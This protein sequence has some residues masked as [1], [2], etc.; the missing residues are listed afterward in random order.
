MEILTQIVIVGLILFA[1][2]LVL[3]PRYLFTIET[4]DGKVCKTRGTGAARIPGG[5]GIDLPGKPDLGRQHPGARPRK[6]HELAFLPP[7]SPASV[8]EISQR[9]VLAPLTPCAGREI[10]G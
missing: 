6:T 7:H 3:Q 5:R 8:P 10:A 9:M 4:T 2:W 1:V